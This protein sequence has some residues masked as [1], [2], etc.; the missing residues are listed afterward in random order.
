MKQTKETPK[1]VQELLE[2]L[3]SN[4]QDQDARELLGRLC[5]KIAERMALSQEYH[6]AAIDFDIVV[7]ETCQ[8]MLKKIDKCC[9]FKNESHFCHYLSRILKNSFYDALRKAKAQYNAPNFTQIRIDAAINN[10]AA[11]DNQ[12]ADD[13]LTTD[14]DLIKDDDFIAEKHLRCLESESSITDETLYALSINVTEERLVVRDHLSTTLKCLK[15]HLKV[16]AFH[17][18]MKRTFSDMSSKEVAHKYGI[19]VNTVDQI[20]CRVRKYLKTTEAHLKPAA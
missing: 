19:S 13:V 20:C 5:L 11:D 12:T 16:K 6:K 10:Y 4:P 14:D 2:M 9:D 7:S 8:K 15:R 3:K 17:I 18:F 1:S